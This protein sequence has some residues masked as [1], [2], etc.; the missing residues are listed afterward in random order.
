[1]TDDILSKNEIRQMQLTLLHPV[2]CF[3]NKKIVIEASKFN[4]SLTI[5]ESEI[6]NFDNK[7]LDVLADYLFKKG[8]SFSCEF[9][10][11]E[12]GYNIRIK[13]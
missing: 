3:L 11:K 8:Y 4:N 2:L 7:C 13:W 12:K 1:M 9:I 6:P 5:N 10:S